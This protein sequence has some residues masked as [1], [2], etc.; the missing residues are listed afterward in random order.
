MRRSKPSRFFAGLLVL[1]MVISLLPM[2]AFAAEAPVAEKVSVTKASDIT[3]GS[4]LIAGISNNAVDDGTNYA[5][6]STKASTD[7]RLKSA[8]YEIFNNSVASYDKVCV[9]NLIKTEGGFYIQN[10]GNEKYLYYGSNSGNCIYQTADIEEAGVWTVVANGDFWTLQENESGRLLS[11]NR[12]GSSGSYYLGFATYTNDESGHCKRA[13]DFY[14]IGEVAQNHVIASLNEL[15]DGA[16]V[17]IYNPAKMMALSSAYSGNYNTGVKLCVENGKLSGFKE[18]ELW[19][20]TSNS[21]GS[22]SFATADGNK[23]SMDMQYT[24]MPLD[25]ANDTWIVTET[26]GGYFINNA[27]RDEANSYRM[28]WHADK[29]NWSS[30]NKNN[31]GDLFVQQF[32]LVVEP[33][34][35]PDDS[36]P[37]DSAAANAPLANGD[38]VV[39]YN[40]ANMKA[41]STEYNGFYNLG[42]DVNLE[43]GIMGGITRAIIW[44][45]SVNSDGTFSF[46]PLDGTEKLAIGASHTS[47]PLGEQFDKWHITSGIDGCYRI[48][49]AG[50]AAYVEWYAENETWRVDGFAN[51]EGTFDL[52][53][54][55]V[56]DSEILKP[57]EPEGDMPKDGDEVVI[58]N[59]T[60]E[61]VLGMPN[62]MNTSLECAAAAVDNGVAVPVNGARVFLVG[63][64]G[65]D[66]TFQSGDLYLASD[67]DENL[68]L[69]DDETANIKWNLEKGTN[70][71]VIYSKDSKYTFSGGGSAKVCI[72]YFGGSFSGWSYKAAEKDIFE[73][74][75]LTYAADTPVTNGVVNKPE[76]I[77]YDSIAYIGMPY[78]LHFSINAMFNYS[79]TSVKLNGEKV[80]F[81][82]ANDY[83]IS[84]PKDKVVGTEL[85]FTVSGHDENGIEFNATKVVPVLKEPVV[86][87][88][89]PDNCSVTLENKRPIISAEI[90]NGGENPAVTMTV[91]K[92]AVK[93]VYKDGIVTYTPAE[94]MPD[95][96]V[97]V[98]VSVIREDGKSAVKTW[99]FTVGEMRYQLY[100]GQLHS[101]TAEYSDGAGTL[102][103][104]LDYISSLPKSAN[105]QFVAFT[106]HSNY[107][108]ENSAAN[109]ESALYDMS[110]ASAASRE[111]WAKYKDTI[112]AFNAEQSN[113]IAIGGFEMTWS[114]GPGH[115]NTFNTPGIVS[116]NNSTLNNKTNDSGMKAYY[117]LLS[118]SEGAIS[119]SQFNHPGTTFGNFSDFSYWD[120]VIDSR[121]FLVEVGNGEGQISAGGYYPSYEQYIMA[122]DK[123]WHVAPTNNQDNHKGKWGNA[124]DARDVILTNDFSEEG[125]Y[126][127]IREMRVY[128]TEDKNLEIYYNING[129]ELGSSITDVPEMLNISVSAHDPD[130]SDAI[131]KVEVVAN[132]GKAVYTWNQDADLATGEFA[133]SVSPD[134]SYYFV[135][136]T[137]RDGDIAVTAPVWVGESLKL[138]ISDLKCGTS[139][140]VTGEELTFSISV[141]NSESKEAVIKSVTYTANGSTVIGIDN[142]GYNVPTSGSIDI[143]FNY[144]PDVAK[145]MTVTATVVIE[146]DGKEFT[147]A[148][149]ITL[150]IRN[151]DELIYI[152]I[153]AAHHNE[154]VAGNYKDSMGNFSELA[155]EF[156]ARTVE[157][158]T[159]D[160]LIA[161]CSNDKIRAIILTAPSRRDGSIL[162]IPYDCYTDD[163][164]AA[165]AGFNSEGG[166]IILAGWSDNY[167]SYSAFPEADHMAAQQNK[168]LA[169]LGSS[170]RIAD[171]GTNDDVLNGGQTQR[172]YFS[173]YNMDSFLMN[174]VEVDDEHPNDVMFTERF[175][176]Y[177]GASIYTVDAAGNPVA[178][179]PVTV[180]PVV[181]GHASTYSKDSDN[182]GVDVPKYS[183]S[184]GDIRLMIMATEQLEG[185]GLIVVSGAAFMSNFE[186]QHAVSD[187][188]AEKNNS[189]Y[190]ICENLV[191]YL[192]PLSVTSI[193][194]IHKQTESGYKYT[195]EG[196]VTTNA[197]GNDKDTAF[198]DCIYVQDET[199]GICCFPVAGDYKIGDKVRITGTTDF[200][201]GE[202]ELQ[203]SSIRKIGEGGTIN[204]TEVS[205]AQINDLSVLGQFITIKGT[206]VDFAL[207]NGLVQTI[208]VKDA[209]GDVARVFID[210]YICSAKEIEN[211][212]IG[213][214]I[215]VSGVSSYDNTFNAPQGPFPRIRIN[216]RANIVCGGV[217]GEPFTDIA[218]SGYHDWIV[219]AAEA[220][221][222]NGYPDNTYRPN[223]TVT[224]A[225]FIT[226][227][228]RA[229]GGSTV[230]MTLTFKDACEIANAYVEAVKWGVANRI[231]NGYGD[232]TFRPNQKIS[233]AQMATFMFRYMNN[234][235]EYPFG[236]VQSVSF[237]DADQI[238]GAYIEAVNAIVST[239]IMSGFNK[240]TFA[241]NET[242]NRGQAATVILRMYKLLNK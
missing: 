227:L 41:L 125:I 51:D 91:N 140:P 124:N 83:V 230:D 171:D 228:Y 139:T 85:V 221:I 98:V 5:F 151:A 131:T 130:A 196:V 46:T 159:S 74:S 45:V 90:V 237:K 54:Y 114:G 36:E 39:I 239:G 145:V 223:A 217:V 231:I 215:T 69:T 3:E 62:D 40:K 80:E 106:D 119:I 53:F 113:I 104:G 180:S 211:L 162:R 115:I 32:Y 8:Q 33:I 146:Q 11:C 173:T 202:M 109:P 213:C 138:G 222:I 188:G 15:V 70:G 76:V 37:T 152:G 96:K 216:D 30:N 88:V 79:L 207:E 177:G 210:G 18:N 75:F 212:A 135:R 176:H 101:H 23:L 105:I 65:N 71:Y 167:E 112:D 84:L 129:Y 59:A 191:Q 199:D 57:A 2:P 29:G 185:K 236:D 103:Q 64:S 184:E 42:V 111:K 48:V 97:T 189:N 94:D 47:M 150:D 205:A 107:F 56:K 218:E 149:D 58:Y 43:N 190:K 234:V 67:N 166:A 204:A 38:K 242:A 169:A 203:V 126:N 118:Q 168:I 182:V 165:L 10:A 87:K 136:V 72:K 160:D 133:V 206:V 164:I 86:G 208:M 22:Y 24:S 21:D 178:E 219:E 92:V 61:G 200:Y 35:E 132:S 197:S 229:V 186:V 63:V 175:S 226:M 232:E 172:L 117:A 158:R 209:K 1:I 27:G 93:S 14:R 25:K 220:G 192:K 81:S 201:Q 225:Q 214:E 179:I 157:L 49:N 99:S 240:D 50:R 163:E 12:F 141:F 102:Q 198:F 4:Y 68:F 16:H 34:E 238:A 122:L 55:I 89:S 147:Y 174:G 60:A 116:R 224:R 128:A 183:V 195:I 154:Y 137:E 235:A 28:Q 7:I 78:T 181:Y 123:G 155:T 110:T 66:F 134:Y 20:V 120:A 170:L 17:V 241:P 156:S 44:T 108:D 187:S 6:M 193:A 26:D 31:D 95:G 153:D 9:W 194:D 148:K 13:L 77:F 100:F 19:T 233:R 161:A 144:I 121:V 127:A 142:K 82:S 143:Q 52:M 73:F